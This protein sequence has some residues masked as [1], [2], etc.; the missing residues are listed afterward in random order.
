M[1][2]GKQGVPK[3]KVNNTMGVKQYAA[4]QKNSMS[5]SCWILSVVLEAVE[6]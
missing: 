1:V 6:V 5:L 2:N 3:K 4:A